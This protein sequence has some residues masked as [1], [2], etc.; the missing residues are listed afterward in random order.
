MKQSKARCVQLLLSE[1][2]EELDQYKW[3]GSVLDKNFS[4]Q[5]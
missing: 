2:Q 4:E 5:H 1:K 3:E